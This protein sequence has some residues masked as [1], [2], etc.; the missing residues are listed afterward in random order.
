MGYNNIYF[1]L[2]LIWLA[3][4]GGVAVYMLMR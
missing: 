2:S 4:I 3:V 1:Y